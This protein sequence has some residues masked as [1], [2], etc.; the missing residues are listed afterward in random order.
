MLKNSCL[1]VPLMVLLYACG[2]S[3]ETPPADDG[4]E[5]TEAPA[6][7]DAGSVDSCVTAIRFPNAITT[8]QA[9]ASGYTGEK[10]ITE[11]GDTAEE[12]AAE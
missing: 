3:A 1:I 10:N 7:L 11:G 2:G 5:V 12:T 9:V 6:E 4:K 8:E